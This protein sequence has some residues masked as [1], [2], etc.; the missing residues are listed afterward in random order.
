M[1][2]VGRKLLHRGGFTLLEVLVAMAIVGLGV[3]MLLQVFSVG[4]RLGAKSS[5]ETEAMAYGRLIM[6][7]ALARRKLDTGPHEGRFYERARWWLRTQKVHEPERTL[8]LASP[9]ELTEVTVAM[10]VRDA[11]YDRR[12]ELKTLRLVRKSEP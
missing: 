10:Q 4:L 7:E 1:K 3:V 11:G 9:W 5:V 12:T 8:S 2:A 6:D